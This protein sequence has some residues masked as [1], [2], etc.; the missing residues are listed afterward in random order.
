MSEHVNRVSIETVIDKPPSPF[1][2]TPE[3]LGAPPL[4]A[5]GKG[6]KICII[7]SGVPDHEAI[8]NIAADANFS[9]TKHNR[10]FIGHSTVVSGLIFGNKPGEFVGIAPD[11]EAYYAKVIDDEAKTRL[12][13]IVAATLWGTIKQCDIICLALCSPIDS[14]SVH[15]AIRKATE[16]GVL[17][18]SCMG[19]R[20]VPAYPA[21]YDDV[22]SVGALTGQMQPAEFCDKG[23]VNV[24][25]TKL[26]STYFEQKYTIVSG[27][28]VAT[29]LGAGLAARFIESR[30]A[31]GAPV[32]PNIIQSVMASALPRI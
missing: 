22:L 29:A 16:S 15:D 9:G 6:V 32:A 12:D 31:T 28:S 13:A 24:I 18:I 3:M 5:T 8:V 19:E 30:R 10:D 23:D 26:I 25:G 17:V 7:D 1:C 20:S 14:P 11:A 2:Y 21:M 27:S 4:Q